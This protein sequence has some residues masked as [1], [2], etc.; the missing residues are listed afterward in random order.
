MKGF[1]RSGLVL[2]MATFLMYGCGGKPPSEELAKAEKAMADAR[3]A[4]ADKYTPKKF[5]EF[6]KAMDDA[7][8]QIE[9]KHY[10]DAKN[11]LL[12]IEKG[13]AD[14]TEAT[15]KAK[16]R[17][18]AEAVA[19]FPKIEAEIAD[20]KKKVSEK[21]L[22]EKAKKEAEASLAKIDEIHDSLKKQ[23]DAGEYYDVKK[24]INQIRTR[25]AELTGE[26]SPEKAG[27]PQEKKGKP[28]HPKG[29]KVHKDKP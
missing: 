18:K 25:I 6:E 12:E 21:K 20:A 9:A 19:E 5:K 10:D 14:L 15:S 4:E 22:D 7:K 16:E 3:T 13:L 28:A 11:A 23:M 2:A 26:K 24:D 8:A 29:N 17:L 27:T 1:V